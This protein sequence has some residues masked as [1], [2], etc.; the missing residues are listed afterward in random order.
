M[1][2]NAAIKKMITKTAHL[3][4]GLQLLISHVHQAWHKDKFLFAVLS[5]SKCEGEG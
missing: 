5:Q 3:T 1:Q 4:T 2:A